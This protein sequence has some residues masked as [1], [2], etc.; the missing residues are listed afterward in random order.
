MTNSQA[1]VGIIR[2]LTAAPLFCDT[3]NKRTGKATAQSDQSSYRGRWVRLRGNTDQ[4]HC[5]VQLQEVQERIKIVLDR[6]AVYDKVEAACMRSHL[7]GI[8]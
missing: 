6:D 7:F 4:C 1:I 5:P 2:R 3:A 8:A